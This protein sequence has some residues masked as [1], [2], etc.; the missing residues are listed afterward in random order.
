MKRDKCLT[1]QELAH[2][3]GYPI[4]GDREKKISGIAYAD[5][6]SPGDL[7]VAYSRQ[8]VEK[9]AAQVILTPPHIFQTRKTYLFAT[10]EINLAML[11]AVNILIQHGVCPDYSAAPDVIRSGEHFIGNDVCIG[12]G[13]SIAPGAVICRGAVLGD[14][15]V[16]GANA[17]IGNDV[18]LGDR[19]RIAPGAKLGVDS[20]FH[21]VSGSVLI[22]F[23]GVGSVHV[24]H[25]AV[26]GGNTNV[27]RGTLSHTVIGPYTQIGGLVEIGHD[28]KIGRSCKIVS[29]TGIAGNV[30][31]DDYVTIYGQCGIVNKV[32]IGSYAVVR[33]K[34]MVT[35]HV[36]PGQTICGPFGREAGI[37][38]RIQ[39]K[40]NRF[41]K[42]GT[43]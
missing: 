10:E 21:I 13:V 40:L 30:V 22:P 25:D 6:A 43:E 28:V 16:I 5:E 1:A 35:K 34:S 18:I 24:G 23:I 4:A 26:I 12:K 11:R 41:L 3:L 17:Y 14:G 27:Q 2:A 20:F 39:A 42:K 15:C 32:H 31:I 37:E 9:T 7:A 38:L 19:V 29:Q 8:E 36:K 33:A